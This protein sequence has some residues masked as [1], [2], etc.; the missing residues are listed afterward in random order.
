MKFSVLMSA[1]QGDCSAHL[2][3]AIGSIWTSQTLKLKE[4]ILDIEGST[5]SKKAD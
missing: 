1:Y 5:F 2:D 4:I 3:I